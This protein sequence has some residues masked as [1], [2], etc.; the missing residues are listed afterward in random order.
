[1]QR[2]SSLPTASLPV[3]P[4]EYKQLLQR[5]RDV[6]RS[7]VPPGATVLVVS[8]GDDDLLELG[9]RPGWHFPRH[10]D[11]KYAGHYPSD[12][13]T[14][15]A[16]LEDLRAEGAEYILFPRTAFWWLD[17]YPQLAEHLQR[18]YHLIARQ[19]HTCLIFGLAER[20]GVPVSNGTV[21]RQEFLRQVRDVAR[22]LLPANA[23]VAIISG[24]ED[25]LVSLA[26]QQGWH[27]P[28]TDAGAHA[29]VPDDSAEAIAHLDAVQAAGA[30]F[31]LIP[32]PALSWMTQYPDFV[33]YL[34]RHHRF[35]TRQ[36]HVC[37][38]Y[39]LHPPETGSRGAWENGAGDPWAERDLRQAG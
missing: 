30:E 2:H 10:E 16:H 15:I 11:G 23:V 25:E 24:G 18:R 28:R 6:V 35:V 29:R 17:H 20:T 13:A 39:E 14:T 22:R 34:R 9:G 12:S 26:G 31:L 38:I 36:E 19:D 21:Q 8:K 7:S 37:E 32:R 33:D 3:G 1:M 5:V 4:L 27:F